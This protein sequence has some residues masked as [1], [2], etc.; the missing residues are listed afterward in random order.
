MAAGQ[1]LILV[2]QR[3]EGAK[4]FQFVSTSLRLRAFA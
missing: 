2:T 1:A 3:R 4:V